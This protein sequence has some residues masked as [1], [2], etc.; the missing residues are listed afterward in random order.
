MAGLAALFDQQPPLEHHVLGDIEHAMPEHWAH[1]MRKPIVQL[2]AAVGVID[3]LNVDARGDAGRN[4][5]LRF[6]E[7]WNPVDD[8]INRPT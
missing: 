3:K 5:P 1:F 8:G 4:R 2:G 7:D 6:F